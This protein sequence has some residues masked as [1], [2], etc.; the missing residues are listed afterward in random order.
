MSLTCDNCMSEFMTGI[1]LSAHILFIHGI[2]TKLDPQI[3]Q[4]IIS[5]LQEKYDMSRRFLSILTKH[6]DKA[7]NEWH[8]YIGFG[9]FDYDD[10][11]CN[12]ES[13]MTKTQ[14]NHIGTEKAEKLKRIYDQTCKKWDSEAKRLNRIVNEIESYNLSEGDFI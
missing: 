2:N 11:Y 7:K 6:T 9:L 13:K 1:D 4:T 12:K 5:K 8:D 10:K 3:D 14:Y